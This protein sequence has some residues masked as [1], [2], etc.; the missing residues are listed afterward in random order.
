MCLIKQTPTN[1]FLVKESTNKR[2]TDDMY[3]RKVMILMGVIYS[4]ITF[5]SV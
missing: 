1:R 5:S 3:K 4:I 2:I